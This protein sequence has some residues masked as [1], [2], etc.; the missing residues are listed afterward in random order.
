LERDNPARCSGPAKRRVGGASGTRFLAVGQNGAVVFSD[1]GLGLNWSIKSAG[2]GN[3]A[4]L[5][6]VVAVPS[7]YLAVGDAGANAV[8]R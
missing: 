5:A 7:M 6:K 1:D 8:S 3:T 2:L 4:N